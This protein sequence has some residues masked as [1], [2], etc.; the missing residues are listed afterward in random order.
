MARPFVSGSSLELMATLHPMESFATFHLVSWRNPFVALARLGLDRWSLRRVEGVEFWRL[1][2]TGRGARTSP[3]ADL[4][5]TAAFIVW[6]DEQTYEAFVA[7]H[8]I[9]ARWSSPRLVREHW[10]TKLKTTGGHGSWKGYKPYEHL[11]PGQ[12]DG[13]VA[14]ITRADIRARSW[15]AFARAGVEVDQE[16]QVAPGLIAVCGIGEAPIGRQGTFSL[17]SSLDDARRFAF[18]T[19][20]HRH[21][22]DETHQENW[23]AEELFARFEPYDADGLWDGRNPLSTAR[24]A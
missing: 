9:F 12:A 23:Y 22:I 3:S 16:L 2:G 7:T 18:Q 17:W 4:S 6:K 20:R 10:S 14:V 1:C 5:R 11:S 15:R 21:V 24:N 19:S 13:V 8:S